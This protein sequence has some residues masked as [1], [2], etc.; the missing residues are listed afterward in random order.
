M[1]LTASDLKKII[2]ECL[3]NST[4]KLQKE[5][6]RLNENLTSEI[7]GNSQSLTILGNEINHIRTQV[8]ENTTNLKDSM[9]SIRDLRNIAIGTDGQNGLRGRIGKLEDFISRECDNNDDAVKVLKTEIEGIKQ[10]KAKIIGIT[11]GLWLIGSTM[12]GF[13]VMKYMDVMFNKSL[14]LNSEKHIQQK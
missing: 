1:Q 11:I 14:E 9:D 8:H 7:F 13:L 6:S 4:D 2:N 12:M 3:D 10:W 5:L